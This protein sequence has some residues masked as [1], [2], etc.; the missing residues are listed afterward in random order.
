MAHAISTP[1]QMTLPIGLQWINAGSH[2]S[3]L[4]T[5]SVDFST[6][7]SLVICR[8]IHTMHRMRDRHKSHSI[9]EHSST[10]LKC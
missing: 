5:N 4:L 6:P 9:T 8:A 10:T 7:K 2:C 3:Y 1:Y